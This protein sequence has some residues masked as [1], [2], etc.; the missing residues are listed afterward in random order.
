MI[1]PLLCASTSILFTTR[2]TYAALAPHKN[3]RKRKKINALTHAHS[4]HSQLCVTTGVVSVRVC[5]SVC[6]CRP[7]CQSCQPFVMFW[8][9]R[10]QSAH[11]SNV[12]YATP[13]VGKQD[14]ENTSPS[15]SCLLPAGSCPLPPLSDTPVCPV[16]W[17]Q[18]RPLMLAL[19][20]KT[21]TL[22]RHRDG[23]VM[24]DLHRKSILRPERPAKLRSDK[25]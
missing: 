17:R 20:N 3:H 10:Y 9:A 12:K 23:I 15:V 8:L 18:R 5:V 19:K 14:N 16:C 11:K 7:V 13:D 1:G 4:K 6:V 24:Q 22:G 21:N 2:C 25:F